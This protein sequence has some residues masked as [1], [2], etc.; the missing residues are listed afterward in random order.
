MPEWGVT[1]RET[2]W[3][4]IDYGPDL[5]D[6]PGWRGQ[7]VVRDVAAGVK[8]VQPPA[9][10]GLRTWV[11][12]A[13][14]GA[15]C[16]VMPFGGDEPPAGETFLELQKRL[17]A[18]RATRS[19]KDGDPDLGRLDRRIDQFLARVCELH[20]RQIPLGFV[21][22]RSVLFLSAA[23]DVETMQL[24]DLGFVFDVEAWVMGRPS[25][26]SDP[27]NDVMFDTSAKDRNKSYLA[28]VNAQNHETFQPLAQEDV[29]IAARL[30]AFALAGE[31]EVRRWCADRGTLVVPPSDNGANDTTC[32]AV[33]DVLDRAIRGEVHSVAELR[34]QL[35]Q[36]GAAG[37]ARPSRH[38]L[39]KPPRKVP[40]WERLLR[41]LAAPV[42]AAVGAI[43]V[44]WGGYQAWEHF[45]PRPTSVCPH[46]TSWDQRLFPTLQDLESQKPSAAASD[47]SKKR[48]IDSL[49][50]YV[51]LLRSGAD[52][53]CDESCT[54]NLLAITEPWIDDQVKSLVQA[55]RDQPRH[56]AEEIAALTNERDRVLGLR[57][58]AKESSP[59]LFVSALEKLDRQLALR[60]GMPSSE[61]EPSDS[62][63]TGE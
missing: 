8:Y 28:W 26:L 32:R 56:N 7:A 9:V 3:K 60:G 46:V 40:W 11:R 42:A 62:Q 39:V 36:E 14:G 1:A 2:S 15:E 52:H 13:S 37:D 6:I 48:F 57:S 54:T 61:R 49:E 44:A 33:W 43:L 10:D 30:I 45:R 47:D 31:T 5:E 20:E 24:P 41:R 23:D 16:F 21:Q 50:S 18:K 58:L 51:E 12:R 17:A 27:A 4:Q 29:R 22:P 34:Q 38:F 59:P 55:L 25:W 53:P 35:V 19:L 63:A